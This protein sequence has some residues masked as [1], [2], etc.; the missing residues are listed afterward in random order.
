MIQLDSSWKGFRTTLARIKKALDESKSDQE[1]SITI[2]GDNGI[3]EYSFETV[4]TSEAIKEIFSGSKKLIGYVYISDRLRHKQILFEETET[5]NTDPTPTKQS[6]PTGD[7]GNS[8]ES[9]V[10]QMKMMFTASEEINRQRT[11]LLT[12][13]FNQQLNATRV[14]YDE[15]DKVFT[16]LQRKEI[17]L[18]IKEVEMSQKKKTELLE[19]VIVG[20]GSGIKETIAWAKE[21]PGDFAEVFSLLR[22][23][24]T[25]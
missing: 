6:A 11:Q 14:M 8:L 18:R 22:S 12:D 25:N 7:F 5:V 1:I 13:S 24:A 15:R 9:L 20:I 21:N 19:S 3:Q 10:T 2:E 16:E 17:E 23:K 4:P